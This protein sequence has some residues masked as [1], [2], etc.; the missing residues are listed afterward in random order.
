MLYQYICVFDIKNKIE[1]QESNL[2]ARAEQ[3]LI[4]THLMIYVFQSH[5]GGN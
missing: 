4:Y 5:N 2:G 1:K 3:K